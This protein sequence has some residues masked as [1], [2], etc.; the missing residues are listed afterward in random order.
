M[1]SLYFLFRYSVNP[2]DKIIFNDKNKIMINP[3]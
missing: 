3:E 2:S 1:F